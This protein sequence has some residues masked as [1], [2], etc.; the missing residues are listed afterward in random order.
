MNTIHKRRSLLMLLLVALLLIPMLA[1]T[2]NASPKSWYEFTFDGRDNSVRGTKTDKAYSAGVSVW[3]D[4]IFNGG[5]IRFQLFRP[6]TGLPMGYESDSLYGITSSWPVFYYSDLTF[7][8]S[9][10]VRM[11]GFGYEGMTYAEGN[12]VP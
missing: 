7:N 8:G 5:Y 4:S 3:E 1:M 9:V 11:D 10:A 2:A 6:A 12:F